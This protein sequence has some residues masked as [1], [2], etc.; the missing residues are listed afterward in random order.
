MKNETLIANATNPQSVTT[1]NDSRYNIDRANYSLI[2]NSVTI[3][4]SADYKCELAVVNPVT[5]TKQ[6]LQPSP[7]APVSLSLQVIGK[8]SYQVYSL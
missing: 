8:Y 3:N 1:V 5:D 6:L 7:P 2:I 4:D